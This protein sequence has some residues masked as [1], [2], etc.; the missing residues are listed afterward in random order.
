MDWI[1]VAQDRSNWLGYFEGGDAHLG[2][3]KSGEFVE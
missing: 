3:I 2:A 1:N